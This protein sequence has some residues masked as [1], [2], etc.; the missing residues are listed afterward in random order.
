M[1]SIFSSCRLLGLTLLAA[2]F[3]ATASCSSTSRTDDVLDANQRR[4]V[5][6]DKYPDFS[7][8]LDSAM[9][10]MSDE[11]AARIQAQL[12]ALARQRKAG[13]VSEAEYWRRVKA[14]QALAKS[15]E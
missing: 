10:Q 3:L 7:Q 6:A 2:S 4:P 5:A 14:L 1:P 9:E 11:D 13:T 15:T 8:P 12:T